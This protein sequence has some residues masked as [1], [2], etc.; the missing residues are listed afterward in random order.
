MEE[1]AKTLKLKVPLRPATDYKFSTQIEQVTD[2]MIYKKLYSDLVSE[3]NTL[4][5]AN[6]TSVTN[7]SIR[8]FFKETLL[9]NLNTL[10][11]FYKYG[12][13][14]TWVD[15]EPSYKSDK[16]V[17]S[18]QISISEA[19]NIWEH[20]NIRYDQLRL[21]NF[22][23]EV[24]HDKE[25]KTALTMGL[26]TLNKQIRILE[27]LALKFEVPLP[28]RIPSSM[29]SSID[30]EIMEDKFIYRTI[31]TGQQYAAMLHARAVLTTTRNDKLRKVFLNL[32]REELDIY[33]SFVK[34][35][36]LKGWLYPY[37]MYTIS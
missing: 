22:F 10:E 3:I 36:K 23:L 17:E 24:I 12:K 25:F 8:M 27:E 15:V 14:K 11:G 7:D 20:I 13:L 16:P 29:E 2:Q 37:P 31:F 19:F 26:N 18:E 28:E 30:P 1:K 5:M 4:V 35:G 6:R 34:Y 21:T 33:N 9:K 32:L